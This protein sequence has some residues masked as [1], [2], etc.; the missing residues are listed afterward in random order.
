[1]QCHSKLPLPPKITKQTIH[2]LPTDHIYGQ[3]QAASLLSRVGGLVAEAMWWVGCGGYVVGVG[4]VI[5]KLKA[6]L[7]STSHLTS[8]LELSMAIQVK[9]NQAVEIFNTHSRTLT[10]SN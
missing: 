3:F 8:R 6:N 9:W 10:R 4:V 2:Q 7:S 1:M 5:I